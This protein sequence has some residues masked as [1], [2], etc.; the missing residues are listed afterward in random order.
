MGPGRA[1]RSPGLCTGVSEN[2][3]I[4]REGVSIK[5][6]L[7]WVDTMD[8]RVHCISKGGA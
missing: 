4:E 8:D 3:L 1:R 2:P 6:L 5:L 7:H